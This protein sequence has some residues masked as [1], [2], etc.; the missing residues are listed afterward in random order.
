MLE[1]HVGGGRFTLSRIRNY[2]RQPHIIISLVLLLVLV[3]IVIIPFIKMVA[4]SVIWQ[5]ADRRLSRAARPGSL[6]LFH[7]KRIFASN[8]TQNV[9]LRPL[10]NSLS[11]SLGIS[12]FAMLIGSLLAWVVVR[13][14][15]PGRRVVAALAVIP[16]V[17]PSY[18]HA[19][20]WLNLFKNDRIGGAA[21]IFQYVFGVSPPNC[22][23]Y[24]YFPIIF[25]LAIHYFPYTYLLVSASLKNI[26]SRLEES[27]EILGASRSYILKRI[28]FPLVLPALLSSFI[29][30]FSRALG[31][32]GTPYFLGSPVRVFTLTTQIY[33]NITNRI[34]SSGYILAFVLILI[35][36][37]I[38]FFNQ[39][40]IGKRKSFVTIAGKGFRTSTTS[41]G[42]AK[43][44]ILVLVV[45]LLIISVLM[46]FVLILWQT[47]ALYPDNYSLKELTLHFWIG[48][49][50]TEFAEG[51]AGILRNPAILRATWNSV[52]LALVAAIV[53]GFIGIFIGY[54]VVKGRNT[55]LS[56]AVEQISFLPYLVPGIAF[57]ALYLSLFTHKIGPIPALYGTFLLIALVCIAKNLPF[58]GRAGI[59]SM[60]Q[61]GSEL[62]E[63]SE[64]TG[65]R[66]SRGFRK[67]VLP[68]TIHGA[69]SG[70]ILVFITV[71]REL[72]LIILLVTPET[73]TL[74]TMTFRYQEQGYTQF[75]S[76]ISTLIIII[77]VTGELLTRRFV[78]RETV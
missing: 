28:T 16:Y 1:A 46:P 69:L 51:E 31:I 60:L 4:D 48:R 32:F 78:K 3:F 9:L 37:V 11:T 5:Y 54:A 15:L 19:L 35:S 24:G 77:V 34:T 75:S 13:T 26:D 74:T 72:S 36:S 30:T 22:V 70:F 56:N 61:I 33:S 52:K 12:A 23:S 20:A 39:R 66:W 65:A 25:T 14:D 71:M 41:L 55:R 42:K 58:T 67:I 17:I 44:A 45:I 49:S 8:L 63:A 10:F 53:S 7:W 50:N 62:E 18:I 73:R 21:G 68:L 43:Y 6:T 29:L 27:G 59:S 64:V 47:F 76:A 38:I 40:I 57:G 2:L